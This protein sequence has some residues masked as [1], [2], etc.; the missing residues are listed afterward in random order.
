MKKFLLAYVKNLGVTFYLVALAFTA[1]FGCI[2]IGKLIG[3]LFGT[4]VGAV[5]AFLVL[6][7]LI[8]NVIV[9]AVKMV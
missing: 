1:I 6:F 3:M 2:V 9:T 4:A 8:I 5:V 7:T